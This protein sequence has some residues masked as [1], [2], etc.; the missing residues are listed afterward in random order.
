MKNGSVAGRAKSKLTTL[1]DCVA[2]LIS[3]ASTD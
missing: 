3:L 1:R 2:F